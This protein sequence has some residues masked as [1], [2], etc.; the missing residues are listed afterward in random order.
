[1]ATSN[2]RR[3]TTFM[4]RKARNWQF[5]GDSIVEDSSARME[6]AIVSVQRRHH[7]T[8]PLSFVNHTS[9]CGLIT[10]LGDY[11]QLEGGLDDG[12]AFCAPLY[13]LPCATYLSL[14]ERKPVSTRLANIS[15]CPFER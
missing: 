6:V 13:V 2:R 10:S 4:T 5:E 7:R 3:R 15:A 1:I 14:R 11:E 8:P 12:H 9:P